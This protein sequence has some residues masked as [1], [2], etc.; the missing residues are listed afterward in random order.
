[1]I[2]GNGLRRRQSQPEAT[3]GACVATRERLH[4]VFLVPLG[5][6]RPFVLDFND[7]HVVPGDHAHVGPRTVF[8]GIVDQAVERP[9]DIFASSDDDGPVGA[10]ELDRRSRLGK[11][12]TLS[13]IHI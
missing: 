10:L 13:L 11:V 7:P 1:M 4:E 3:V 8:D 12:L 6:A 5:N 2:C 9:F